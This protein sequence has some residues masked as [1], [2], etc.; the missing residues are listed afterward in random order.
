MDV[1][2]EPCIICGN[3]N[4]Q[5]G[6]VVYRDRK[7]NSAVTNGVLFEWDGGPRFLGR[8][9]LKRNMYARE[10]LVCGNVQMFTQKEET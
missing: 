8:K 3:V 5:F 7:N 4:Y 9:L 1:M 6:N 10:C 2:K